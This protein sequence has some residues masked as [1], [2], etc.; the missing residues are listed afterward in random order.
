[1]T[2]PLLETSESAGK[3]VYLYKFQL[4][5]VSGLPSGPPP[6]GGLVSAVSIN[7]WIQVR[8]IT[9]TSGGTCLPD[10]PNSAICGIDSANGFD[11]GITIFSRYDPVIVDDDSGYFFARYNLTEFIEADHEYV[12][13]VLA[14]KV[15]EG[16]TPESG[17]RVVTDV[18]GA[19]EPLSDEWEYYDILVTS[20]PAAELDLEIGGFVLGTGEG[21]ICGIA[22]I[23]IYDPAIEPPSTPEI[24]VTEFFRTSFRRPITYESN[25]YTPCEI[26]HSEPSQGQDDSPGD[27]QIAIPSDDNI[28]TILLSSLPPP[29]PMVTIINYHRPP[30]DEPTEV[31]RAIYDIISVEDTIHGA[32]LRCASLLSQA[33]MIVPAGLIQR[34]TCAWR[35]YDPET[36]QVDPAQF[37]YEGVV[38]AIDG[39]NVTLNIGVANFPADFFTLG[40]MALGSK[41]VMIRKH[42][43]NSGSRIFTLHQAIPGLAIGNLVQILAGDDRTKETCHNKFHNSA[44]RESFPRM[45]TTNPYY[46]QGLRP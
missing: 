14:R 9:Q 46:G 15:V 34:D 22:S 44:R 4:S 17:I 13:R 31:R 20:G 11:K 12:I 35:T 29:R 19:I 8:D 30:I 1:M 7:G 39:F 24:E 27:I 23:T 38:T 21:A 16:G 10:E 3:P 6:P 37:T 28:V 18:T 26:E 2:F 5:E 33:D 32:D 42:A 36:C 40:E 45:P 25:I 41:R 43:E